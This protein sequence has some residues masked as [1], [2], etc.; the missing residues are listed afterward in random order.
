MEADNGA[1]IKCRSMDEINKRLV[2]LSFPTS[3]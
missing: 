1:L 3:L 2:G